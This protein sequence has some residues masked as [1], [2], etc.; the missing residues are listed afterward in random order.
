MTMT[1]S[2]NSVLRRSSA[3]R[4]RLQRG[5]VMLRKRII[6][7][8]IVIASVALGHL[9]PTL[10]ADFGAGSKLPPSD[11]LTA[12]IDKGTVGAW[13]AN[14]KG[15]PY[16][17]HVGTGNIVGKSNWMELV[18]VNQGKQAPSFYV[19]HKIGFTCNIGDS[20]FFVLANTSKQIFQ[21]RGLKTED[22]VAAVDKYEIFKYKLDADIMDVW[23]VDQKFLRG[24]IKSGQI[25]G[26]TAT[27]DDTTENLISFIKGS[28]R[29][30]LMVW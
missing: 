16:Y 9:Q 6:L 23:A 25:K 26:N 3:K 8:L 14:F 11:P 5:S 13:F 19:H 22:L 30:F 2:K 1:I 15:K 12:T 27:I 7:L 18:L 29:A 28:Y 17:L 21:L 10:A 4:A 20:G 24:A